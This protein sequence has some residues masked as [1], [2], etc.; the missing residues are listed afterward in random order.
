MERTF[1]LIKPD[2]VM[3][4]LVGRLI[5][6]FEEKGLRLVGLKLMQVSE[7]LA[8]RHYGEH[9][10]KPFFPGLISYITSA[11]VVAMVFEGHQA[12]AVVRALVGA[13]DP[14]K[15]ASGTIRGD[16][17]L[18]IDRNVVHASDSVT[19][20]E[21]EMDIFFRPEELIGLPRPEEA[22]IDPAAEH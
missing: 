3:R 12:V 8:E 11:P 19:S 17:A 9:Q 5:Q 22:W 15:A 20:A 4:H 18:T 13:T 7:Q 16:W 6:R 21:R 2:G 1:I 10:G 14:A